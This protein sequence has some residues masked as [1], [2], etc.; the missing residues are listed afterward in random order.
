V[1][2]ALRGRPGARYGAEFKGGAAGLES[3]FPDSFVSAT[4]SDKP[5][6]NSQITSRHRQKR[7]D[8]TLKG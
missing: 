3:G 8:P 5:W 7:T 4:Y 6:R 2:A 1:G